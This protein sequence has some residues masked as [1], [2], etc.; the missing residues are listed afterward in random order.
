MRNLTS[1][2]TSHQSSVLQPA[3]E[4]MDTRCVCTEM[5][6]CKDS[7]GGSA[8][9]D[10]G[11]GSQTARTPKMSTHIHT[12][13][14]THT[15]RLFSILDSVMQMHFRIKEFKTRRQ[16]WNPTLLCWFWK[17][18]VAGAGWQGRYLWH[19]A[20]PVCQSTLSGWGWVP[21][22]RSHWNYTQQTL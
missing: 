16:I 17:H 1:M 21:H 13:T 22:G 11:Q 8:G 20:E 15:D 19:A 6:G 14:H 2:L 7:A 12:H 9:P 10:S 18:T 5:L 3:R 4:Q